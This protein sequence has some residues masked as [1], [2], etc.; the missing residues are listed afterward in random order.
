M[1]IDWIMHHFLFIFSG[2]VHKQQEPCK[3]VRRWGSDNNNQLGITKPL[4]MDTVNEITSP[5][6]MECPPIVPS[7]PSPK[8]LAMPETN[9]CF[10]NEA[11]K[12]SQKMVATVNMNTAIPKQ[13]EPEVNSMKQAGN[14]H[15]FHWLVLLNLSVCLR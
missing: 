6:I 1:Y 14:N 9:K 7:K 3:R 2:M 10:S 13:P 15:F 11:S 4:T 8:I 12:P 5:G